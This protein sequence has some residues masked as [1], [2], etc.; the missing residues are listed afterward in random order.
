MARLK[1]A[2]VTF[3]LTPKQ[4]K[5]RGAWISDTKAGLTLGGVQYWARVQ[6]TNSGFLSV[7]EVDGGAKVYV[8]PQNA[9]IAWERMAALHGL[10]WYSNPRNDATTYDLAIQLLMFGERKYA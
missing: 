7:R 10:D 4:V 2:T 5:S 9:L 1:K 8:T 6:G 3:Q